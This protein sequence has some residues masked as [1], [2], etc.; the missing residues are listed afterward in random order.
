MDVQTIIVALI[1]LGALGYAGQM[2]WRRTK[3]FAPKNNSC[4]ADCGC[5]KKQK[6]RIGEK[7]HENS[8]V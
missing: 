4:A 6:S 8:K 2:L 3:S 1:V 7:L 5:E